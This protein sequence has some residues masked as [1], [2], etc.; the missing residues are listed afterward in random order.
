MV[1][2]ILLRYSIKD[3]AREREG[4]LKQTET[5]IDW[6]ELKYCENLGEKAFRTRNDL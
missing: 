5:D 4:G 6:D 3:P 1:H 2:S